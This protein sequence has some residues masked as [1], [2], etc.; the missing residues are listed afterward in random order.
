MVFTSPKNDEAEQQ[1]QMIN[2]L[3]MIRET[4]EAEASLCALSFQSL[5][6]PTRHVWIETDFDGVGIGL[7]LEDWQ[8]ND[9]GDDAVARV[10]ARSTPDTVEI[11]GIWLS[12]ARLSDWYTNV[13]QEY[14]PMEPRKM[15][16]LERNRAWQLLNR[17]DLPKGLNTTYKQPVEGLR[18]VIR[19]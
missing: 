19:V 3:P 1:R 8:R 17:N 15:I 14:K 13:N 12:G 7:D 11:V 6:V 10:K 16:Q 4:D 18:A 5:L 2:Q 9:D